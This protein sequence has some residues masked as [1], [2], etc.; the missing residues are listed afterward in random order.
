MSQGTYGIVRAADVTPD[1][2][3]IFYHYSPS[4]D[5]I[6]NTSLIKIANTND[7]LIKLDNPNKVDSGNITA[8]EL[9]GGMYTLKLP[10]TIFSAKGFYTLIIKPV[11]IRTKIVDCGV[12]SAYPDIKGLVFDIASVPPN[13][14]S[15]FENNGLVVYRI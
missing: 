6:G 15:K 11:E 9:F 7:V 14:Q 5:T 2:V 12:L 10:T 8:T 4:R 1:D 3:E 13:F